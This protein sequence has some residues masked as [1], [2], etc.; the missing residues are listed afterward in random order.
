M[1]QLC[2]QPAAMAMPP[3]VSPTTFTGVLFFDVV[4]SPKSPYLLDPQHITLPVDTNPQVCNPPAAMAMNLN[5]PT[6]LG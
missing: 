1:A 2:A 3:L 4:P 5:V 6:A